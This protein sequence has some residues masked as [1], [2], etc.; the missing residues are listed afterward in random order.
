MPY[1][2]L[3]LRRGGPAVYHMDMNFTSYHLIVYRRA[4]M[5]YDKKVKH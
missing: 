5:P 3:F 1:A 2:F 4:L